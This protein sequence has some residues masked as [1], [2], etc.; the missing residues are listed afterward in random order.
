MGR[1]K[2]RSTREESAPSEFLLSGLLVI[3]VPLWMDRLFLM[4]WEERD[5]RRSACLDVLAGSE[6]DGVACLATGSHTKDGK[7]GE[8]FNRL[9]EA[10]ALGALQPGGVTF[11]GMHF[12]AGE[13][14][15][16]A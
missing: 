6:A 1:A 9:A 13:P 10:L 16:A 12:E 2:D 14:P 3:A 4:S 11:M 7:V 5:R 15:K 8:A